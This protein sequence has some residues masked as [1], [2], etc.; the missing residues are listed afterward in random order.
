MTTNQK[1]HNELLWSNRIPIILLAGA[2]WLVCRPQDGLAL[3]TGHFISWG[4][5]AGF[6]SLAALVHYLMPNDVKL[7]EKSSGSG[8]LSWIHLMSLYGQKYPQL[9][10]I[11]ALTCIYSTQAP[12]YIGYSYQAMQAL[13]GESSA[14]YIQ[15][16]LELLCYL[17]GCFFFDLGLKLW[18]KDVSGEEAGNFIDAHCEYRKAHESIVNNEENKPFQNIAKLTMSFW[19]YAQTCTRAAVAVASSL[20][21]VIKFPIPI[22]FAKVKQLLLVRSTAVAFSFTLLTYISSAWNSQASKWLQKTKYLIAEKIQEYTSG[23][24]KEK[25]SE[26]KPGNDF[27]EA[28]RQ[29]NWW[30]TVQNAYYDLAKGLNKGHALTMLMIVMTMNPTFPLTGEFTVA[31]IIALGS[32]LGN[33]Q[34]EFLQVA[35]VMG[36]HTEAQSTFANLAETDTFK[37]PPGEVIPGWYK[38]ENTL[39][40]STETSWWYNFLDT[41]S[42]MTLVFF[43]LE[44]RFTSPLI[45]LNIPSSIWA[46]AVTLAIYHVGASLLNAALA[47]NKPLRGKQKQENSWLRLQVLCCNSTTGLF[48]TRLASMFMPA[49]MLHVFYYAAG[50]SIHAQLACL[51]GLTSL[52]MTLFV[53][54]KLVA[55]ESISDYLTAGYEVIALQAS[56]IPRAANT[57]KNTIINS[58]ADTKDSAPDNGYFSGVLAACGNI[59]SPI[60]G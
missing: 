3:A 34:N 58:K 36:A 32:V 59:I 18:S 54:P 9:I 24:G 13:M 41:I 26:E 15:A 51:G 44:N 10:S 11:I 21:A 4:I 45:M 6:A 28:L 43:V 19:Y 60:T 57:I 31:T 20:Y 29:T 40:R 55:Q 37:A 8:M 30:S 17:I 48:V 16:S 56:A 2:L 52:F 25:P 49:T 46:V 39:S 38:K 27:T 47:S 42:L 23:I 14:A 5:V 12:F 33:M 53:T 50:A 7:S 22:A 1:N 35:R